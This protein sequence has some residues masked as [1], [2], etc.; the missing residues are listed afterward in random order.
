M[1][2]GLTAD[3]RFYMAYNQVYRSLSREDFM[4]QALATDPHSPGEWRGAEV[5]NTDSWYEAFAVKPG[6]KMYLAPQQRAKIW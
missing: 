4:R 2:G 6:Q 1:I 3:Q 5:R